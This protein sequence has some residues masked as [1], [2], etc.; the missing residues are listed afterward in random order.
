MKQCR[1]AGKIGKRIWRKKSK[2]LRKKNREKSQE[3]IAKC[4]QPTA[5]KRNK[6]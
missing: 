1:G 4:Q 2:E 6:Q 5:N 3:P